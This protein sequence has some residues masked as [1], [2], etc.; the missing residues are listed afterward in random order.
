MTWEFER[1]V[2]ARASREQ[3]WSILTNVAD[4]PRWNPGVGRV[5][6]EEPVT[7]GAMG[8]IRAPGGPPSSLKILT[9]EPGRR[10]VTETSER[11]FRL[12][13]DQELADGDNGELLISYRVRM[14]GPATLLVRHTVGAR[15]KRSIPAALAALV[16]LTTTVPPREDA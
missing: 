4:W 15:L 14:T 12:R 3:V 10:L 13:F 2:Q 6:L 9:I 1:S 8:T 7:V 5:Q 11:L 16:D